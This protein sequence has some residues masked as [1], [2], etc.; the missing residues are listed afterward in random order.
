MIKHSTI[1]HVIRP[2]S[3]VSRLVAILSALVLVTVFLC[4]KPRTRIRVKIGHRGNGQK[5]AIRS[6]QAEHT[7]SYKWASQ[8]DLSGSLAIGRQISSFSHAP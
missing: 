6:F 4:T 1:P 5:F 7:L 2:T 8:V 3:N